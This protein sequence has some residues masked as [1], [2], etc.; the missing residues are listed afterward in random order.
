MLTN[1]ICHIKNEALLLPPW[2]R[3]HA[4]LFDTVTIIDYASTDE[5]LDIVRQMAPH[6]RIVRSQNTDFDANDADFE[7]MQIEWHLSGW[8]LALNVTEYV[9]SHNL[10]GVLKMAEDANFYGLTGES[11]IL[12]DKQ[13]HGFAGLRNDI[14]VLHQF[15]HGYREDPEIKGT[16]R[17]LIHRWKTGSYA[18][19]RHTWMRGP[20]ALSADVLFTTL[21]YAPWDISMIQRKLNIGKEVSAHDK[22]KGLGFHHHRNADQLIKDFEQAVKDSQNLHEHEMWARLVGTGA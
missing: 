21:M 15:H 12:A 19:G 20:T 2:I 17:R 13:R 1:L 8:K 16:R 5:S 3:H 6:W 9:A 22:A 7:V 4:P 10:R 11:F 18:V 14:P